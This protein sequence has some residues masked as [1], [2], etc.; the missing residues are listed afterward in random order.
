MKMDKLRKCIKDR[1]FNGALE[2]VKNSKIEDVEEYLIEVMF[3]TRSIIPYT[4]ICYLISQKEDANLHHA[5]SVMLSQPLCI[6][7][8]AYQAALFHLKQAI[9]LDPDN[10]GF[11]EF[12]LFFYHTPD[13]LMTK[14]EAVDMANLILFKEPNNKTALRFLSEEI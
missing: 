14:E 1:D 6:L 7:E 8:G 5:A 10:I 2:I 3:E 4:I 12:Y 11:K 9:K 13:E